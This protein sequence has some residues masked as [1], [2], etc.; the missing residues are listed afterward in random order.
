MFYENSSI[1]VAYALKLQAIHP[2]YLINLRESSD[3]YETG[4]PVRPVKQSLVFL[5]FGN[6]NLPAYSTLHGLLS[7]GKTRETTAE[8]TGI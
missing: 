3:F 7:F 1:D 6:V 4:P 2:S 5:F 8:A